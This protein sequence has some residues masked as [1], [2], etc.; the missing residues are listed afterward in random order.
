MTF[1]CDLTNRLVCHQISS[2]IGCN[3]RYNLT[4][5]IY[6]L[7]PSFLIILSDLFSKLIID[8]LSLISISVVSFRCCCP[9]YNMSYLD[10]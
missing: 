10:L 6:S 9:D 1:D 2:I 3:D 4:A 8:V 7:N 5:C